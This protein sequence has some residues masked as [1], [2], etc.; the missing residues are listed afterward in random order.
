MPEGGTD[1]LDLLLNSL[2]ILFA[3]VAFAVALEAWH[4]WSES[5]RFRKHFEH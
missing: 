5:R 1:W 4:R 3:G 2:A